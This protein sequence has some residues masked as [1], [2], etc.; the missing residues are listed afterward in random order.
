MNLFEI[1]DK[2]DPASAAQQHQCLGLDAKEKSAI[3]LTLCDGPP[4]QVNAFVDDDDKIAKDQWLE[5]DNAHRIS[6]SQMVV[7][8]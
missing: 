4:A 8:I 7:N 3:T 2:L 1:S 6:N 5:L